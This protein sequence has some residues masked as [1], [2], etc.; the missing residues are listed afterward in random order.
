MLHYGMPPTKPGYAVDLRGLDAVVDYPARDMTI[1]VGAGITIAKLQAILATEKQRL[2]IDVPQPALATLGG[3]IAVNASGPRRFGLG[4]LRDYVIG[5]SFLTDGGAEAKAG[6]RVVKNVAGYDLCKLHIG[7]LGTLGIVTQV[8]LKLKPVPEE[9]KLIAFDCRPDELGTLLESV[10]ASQTRP[11]C[12]EAIADPDGHRLV[13]GF[14][15]S[16]DAVA[17]QI[18]Q[19]QREIGSSGT[20]MIDWPSPLVA[21]TT[22]KAN[23]PPSTLPAF[24]ATLDRHALKYQASA[25]NGI[26]TIAIGG[27]PMAIVAELRR[28][29]AAGQGSVVVTRCL[30]AWNRE[31]NVWGEPRG[32]WALMKK[33][34][35]ELDPQDIFNPGRFVV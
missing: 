28:A 22:L 12:V 24:L 33:V 8:T 32:D 18:D 1:T 16:R 3:A 31:L 10:H 21:E 15:D 27:E 11:T 19:I 30:P 17:W 29:A 13:I 20:Q 9:S 4:T 26:V 7:A 2:P 14:E 6:G 5:I 23:L 34:K 35:R 25:G